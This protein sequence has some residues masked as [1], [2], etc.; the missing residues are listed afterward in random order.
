MRFF[1]FFMVNT[2]GRHVLIFYKINH[3]PFVPLSCILYWSAGVLGY[4]GL[5]IHL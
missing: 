1:S 5:L 3:R 4:W 2:K